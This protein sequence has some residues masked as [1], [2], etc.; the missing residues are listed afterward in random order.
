ML[1]CFES[2]NNGSGQTFFGFFVLVVLLRQS[3]REKYMIRNIVEM[4]K[5][6]HLEEGPALGF[7]LLKSRSRLMNSLAKERARGRL[8]D[9]MKSSGRMM[10]W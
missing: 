3:G 8:D 4:R 10:E 7:A 9:A 2:S 1:V 6:L 5:H